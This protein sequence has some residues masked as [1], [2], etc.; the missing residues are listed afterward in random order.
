MHSIIGVRRACSLQRRVRATVRD[1]LLL[2]FKKEPLWTNRSRCSLQKS[3]SLSSLFKEERHE[4][5]DLDLIFRSQKS[6]DVFDS[7]SQFF[8]FYAQ[9]WIAPVALYKERNRD[10]LFGKERITFF[11]FCSHKTSDLLEKPKSKFTTLL[12]NCYFKFA[13]WSD[14]VA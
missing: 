9:K 12:V 2:L 14:L 6:S 13:V 3:E 11:F 4:W 10:S 7:F 1:L 8:P 5:F